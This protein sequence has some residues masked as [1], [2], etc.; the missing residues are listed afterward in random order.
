MTP[1]RLLRIDG[2]GIGP[3][4]M[5]ATVAVLDA[6]ASR[7][8]RPMEI[9]KAEIGFPALAASG[10]TIPEDVIAQARDAD[11]VLLGPVSHNAYPPK[12][13]GGLNPSGV[14]RAKLELFA[15]IRPAK[16]WP[17]VPRPVTAPLDLVVVRENLEGFYADRNLHQGPGEFMPVPGV[18][19]AFRKI[20]EAGS[21]R[22][23]E[24]AFE[25][26]R[27]R[28]KKHVT[29]VHKANVMRLS[30]GLFLDCVREVAKRFPDVTYDEVLVDAAAALLVRDPGQFDVIVT[31][32]MF[33]DILSDLVSELSG[34]LG[35]AGSLNRGADTAAAQ[36]QH[37]SAPGIAGM[38]C[39]NPVSLILSAAMLLR[40]LGEAQAAEAI[41]SA[42]ASCLASPDTRTSDL[43]GT[44]GTRA[45]THA[46]V[47]ALGAP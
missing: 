40:H 15:N 9:T 35:L 27:Q 4:I 6:V 47:T 30:D 24:A 16:S 13:E 8:A 14:L 12:E 31:T 22:I 38:D 18:A 10:S 1:L 11:G 45:F 37:G 46:V 23:A 32:N 36:A 26:A 44:L 21:R 33:G 42:I 25:I 5:V 17:G 29:A 20:T 43:G 3:E 28:P 19:M 7:M 34:G 41:E 39:A 2:D